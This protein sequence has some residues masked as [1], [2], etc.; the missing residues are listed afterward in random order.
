VFLN[1]TEFI[2]SRFAVYTKLILS[3][4]L[5]KMSFPHASEWKDSMF[6]E[7]SSKLFR[8]FLVY[9]PCERPC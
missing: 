1:V 6:E 7:E 5:A 2:C 3:V 8:G 9:L 4:L